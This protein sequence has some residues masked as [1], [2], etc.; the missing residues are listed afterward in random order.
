MGDKLN[1][2]ELELIQQSLYYTKRKFENYSD[3]PSYEYK[4]QRINEGINEVDE[5]LSKISMMK[6]DQ[7]EVI[8][9]SKSAR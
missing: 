2:S 7:G 4:I 9:K 3:Y 1:V 5:V 8:R 6:K